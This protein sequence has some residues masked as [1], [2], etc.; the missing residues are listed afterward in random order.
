MSV[1][2]K[3]QNLNWNKRDVNQ[4]TQIVVH[5][6]AYRQDNQDNQS[7]FE[8][9]RQFHLNNGWYG[10]SYHYVIFKDG[11]IWQCNNLTDAS[12]TDGVNYPSLAIL[13]DGYFHDNK[14][15]PNLD[16]LKSL[17][18][19]LGD[20]CNNHPEFPAVRAD[21]KAHREVSSTA[22][23]GDDLVNYIIEWRDTGKFAILD[24][25][26]PEEP[27]P[28]PISIPVANSINKEYG[29]KLLNEMKNRGIVTQSQLDNWL[30][31]RLD[32]N[33]AEASIDTIIELFN[34][35]KASEASLIIKLNNANN[36][37]ETEDLK[38]QI[39][40]LQ[41]N[42][43]KS[44]D[45]VNLLSQEL[46]NS[47][48]ELSDLKATKSNFNFN[49]SKQYETFIKS[50]GWKILIGALLPFLNTFS[51]KY[52]GTNISEQQVL[53]V[54][55]IVILYLGGLDSSVFLGKKVAEK[56]NPVQPVLVIK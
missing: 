48:K 16:Q 53:N 33:G 55:S 22:C 19:L 28:A 29:V 34:G 10:L 47:Q 52:F 3:I 46:V 18:Y 6:S 31:P 20:L 24:A 14:D 11:E 49:W 1:L 4:I 38:T 51:S 2:N 50:G 40:L 15:K 44:Q 7:R 42:L 45:Q 27:K 8:S 35:L 23:C 26:V 36:T 25:N 41:D 21:V 56:L 17:D 30:R 13:V 54:L 32:I 9:L 39:T 12:P 5:H 37:V 43:N